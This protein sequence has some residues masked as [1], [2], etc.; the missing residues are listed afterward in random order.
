[1]VCNIPQG[2]RARIVG[3]PVEI[4]TDS[5]QTSGQDCGGRTWAMTEA[6]HKALN[7]AAGIDEQT[8]RICEHVLEMD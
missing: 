1:M 5:M 2:N 7:E 6:S 4:L 8:N 3:M